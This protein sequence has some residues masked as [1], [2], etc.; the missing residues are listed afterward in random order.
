L[1][2]YNLQIT[3]AFFLTRL[4]KTNAGR[5]KQP[6]SSQDKGRKGSNVFTRLFRCC[7]NPTTDKKD[8][9]VQGDAEDLITSAPAPRPVVA[10]LPL[11]LLKKEGSCT[12]KPLDRKLSTAISIE[13][14]FVK[15]QLKT[16]PSIGA[17]ADATGLQYRSD[18]TFEVDGKLKPQKSLNTI[19]GAGI[20]E[21]GLYV[22]EEMMMTEH[23][24]AEF[25]VPKRSV[26]PVTTS[27][28]IEQAQD[29]TMTPCAVKEPKGKEPLVEECTQKFEWNRE[30]ISLEEKLDLMEAY[31]QRTD[32]C[33]C[34]I[35]G[36]SSTHVCPD[37]DFIREQEALL[38]QY[39]ASNGKIGTMF[40]GDCSGL[41]GYNSQE[42]SSSSEML[43]EDMFYDEDAI[44]E[45][46]IILAHYE[47]LNR[48]RAA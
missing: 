22:D 9:V 25:P 31:Q 26:I 12:P 21:E 28:R 8:S 2:F 20:L 35:V 43:Y 14:H 19:C 48:S 38:A 40:V 46:E 15:D 45:Q 7:I 16:P 37:A 23:M 1:I 39:N 11:H 33:Q 24:E 17:A 27:S 18:R 34:H 44:R 10:P 41:E 6:R 36:C 30:G 13:P 47:A 32:I 42:E 3:G 29:E 4:R 5:T